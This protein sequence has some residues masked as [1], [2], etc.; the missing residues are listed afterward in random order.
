MVMHIEHMCQRLSLVEPA[1][2]RFSSN[3]KDIKMIQSHV[4]FENVQKQI[5]S[6]CETNYF[7][8]LCAQN[9]PPVYNC[10]L[11]EKSFPI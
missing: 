9:Y 10:F 4:A 11:L 6:D 1:Y 2:F 3:L 5:N 7:A 8:S